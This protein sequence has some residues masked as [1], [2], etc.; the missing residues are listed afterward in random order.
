VHLPPRAQPPA[1]L[2]DPLSIDSSYRNLADAMLAFG[3]IYPGD[4]DPQQRLLV[5]QVITGA[6]LDRTTV[7][8]LALQLAAV[9]AA[10]PTQAATGTDRPRLT[11]V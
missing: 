9:S 3:E 8:E 2:P 1:D 4:L 7:R 10:A 5:E 6:G 11:L